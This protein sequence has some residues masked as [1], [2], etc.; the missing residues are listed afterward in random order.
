[1]RAVSAKFR[2]R[3]G[4]RRR[5]DHL[6]ASRG[7]QFADNRATVGVVINQENSHAAE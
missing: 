3:P 1:M 2:E 4:R 6:R 7:Q 5:L